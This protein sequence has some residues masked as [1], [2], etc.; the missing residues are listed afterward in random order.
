[1]NNWEKTRQ[2]HQLYKSQKNITQLSRKDEIRAEYV[3]KNLFKKRA[4]RA[5]TALSIKK[6]TWLMLTSPFRNVS[7]DRLTA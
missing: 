2:K 6:P 7:R 1:M 5:N 4:S 3:F